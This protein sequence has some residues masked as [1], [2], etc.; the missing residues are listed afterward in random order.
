MDFTFI[1]NKTVKID[2]REIYSIYST[3]LNY[4]SNNKDIKLP[5][6][7]YSTYNWRYLDEKIK[8]HKFLVE[9]NHMFILDDKKWKI[10]IYKIS[11]NIY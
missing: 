7:R 8:F 10:D 2:I 3:S 1:K 6:L 4:S 9:D 5:G 11:V